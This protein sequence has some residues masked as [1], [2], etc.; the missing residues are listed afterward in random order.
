MLETLALVAQL[1]LRW[2]LVGAA[3]IIG[4]WTEAAFRVEDI[5]NWYLR[6][7]IISSAYKLHDANPSIWRYHE[8]FWRTQ[9][10]VPHLLLGESSGGTSHFILTPITPGSPL[11][12]YWDD[13]D[14]RFLVVELKERAYPLIH[15][16]LK[17]GEA[18]ER[19]A[20]QLKELILSN[21]VDLPCK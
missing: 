18:Y 8:H 11:G 9:P 17:I 19:E 21:N 20:R 10:R 1:L 5:M 13:Y 16:Y 7:D 12:R 3:E 14:W 2:H 4:S 6:P 15:G